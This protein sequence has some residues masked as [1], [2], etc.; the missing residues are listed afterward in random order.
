M[1]AIARACKH[2]EQAQ[3]FLQKAAASKHGGD[4]TWSL[5]AERLLSSVDSEKR[6]QEL[7]TSLSSAERVRDSSSYT[8]W[9]WYNIGTIEAVLDHKEQAE[10]AFR[11]ALLLPDSMMSHHMARAAMADLAVK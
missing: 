6:L 8:G 10:E 3:Q 9:W 5:K 4:A 2:D 11:H 1:A 7:Q